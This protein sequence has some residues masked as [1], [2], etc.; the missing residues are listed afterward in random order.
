[1]KLVNF[2]IHSPVS[3]NGH[4]VPLK[5]PGKA[6]CWKKPSWKS[7]D[8]DSSKN[9]IRDHILIMTIGMSRQN[10]EVWIIFLQSHHLYNMYEF[11][12][13]L[14]MVRLTNYETY[15]FIISKTSPHIP[16]C[17]LQYIISF[18][19][20][21]YYYIF[22]NSSRQ[23]VTVTL[24]MYARILLLLA[25]DFFSPWTL[26]PHSFMG[27]VYFSNQLNIGPIFESKNMSCY[28]E[29]PPLETVTILNSHC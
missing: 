10:A 1:M 3:Q 11:H 12:K 20:S 17:I 4:W 7:P 29:S 22:D 6:V 26:E 8:A 13:Q 24:R 14:G 21:A 27:R 19:I 2:G 18:F 15:S 16:T 5:G 9:H 25:G 28:S 23:K